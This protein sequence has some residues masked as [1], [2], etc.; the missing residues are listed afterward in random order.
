MQL[1]FGLLPELGV[2]KIGPK[3]ESKHTLKGYFCNP[4]KKVTTKISPEENEKDSFDFVN[5]LVLLS[6]LILS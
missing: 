6:E 2:A 1:K 3:D 5:I 4:I